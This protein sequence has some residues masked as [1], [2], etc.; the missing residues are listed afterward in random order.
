MTYLL[1]LDQ[2]TTSSRAILFDQSLTPVAAASRP[3]PQIYPRPAWVEHDPLTIWE[4]QLEAAREAVSLS[5]VRPQ[6]IAAIGITN[7]RETTLVWERATGRPVHNAIVWQCRRTAS[8][9]DQLRRRG[10]E[11][12]VRERTG[13]VIDA[14]FSGPKLRWLLDEVP[15]LRGRALRGEVV[16]GTVDT[17]LLWNLTGSRVHATDASN[18]SR[19]MMLDIHRLAWDEDILKELGIPATML[20]EVRPSAQVYGVTDPSLLG[21]AIP[22]AGCAGDQQAALF[23]QA[24]LEPGMAKNTYGTGCFLLMHTG[25]RAPRSRHGLITTVAWWTGKQVTY[26]LEGSVFVAG[27]AIQWLRDGL[28][29]LGNAAESETLARTVP[30]TGGVYLV[31]AFVGLG[32]PYWDMY[33]R[34]TIVGITRG[35]RQAHLVRA[36]LESICYQTRDVLSAMEADAGPASCLRVDGGAA[37]N[38]FLMQFQ[39]DIL[40]KPVERPRVTETTALGAAALAGVAIG[41]LTPQDVADRWQPQAR[42][43]PGMEATERERLY[44][45]W[46]RAVDRARHWAAPTDSA[47]EPPDPRG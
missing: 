20:P 9:C 42:F 34:G 10:W 8:L 37:V 36:A 18:A 2:G 47:S 17:W 29:L 31:P 16:F 14:Y 30:D 19:T 22:V 44:A 40:G 6:E 27:A 13:L 46:R 45:G 11:E 39:A 5:G 21:A 1:A 4:T 28:G 12:P 41:L 26:A 32:A 35:T 38:D 43:L 25:S 3:L 15:N 7:Q 33:A 23:G 24:C